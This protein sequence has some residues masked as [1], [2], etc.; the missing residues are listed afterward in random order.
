MMP[1]GNPNTRII[2]RIPEL[3]ASAITVMLSPG[4]NVGE[5][6]PPLTVEVPLWTAYPVIGTRSAFAGAAAVTI[7]KKATPLVIL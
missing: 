7:I 6:G 5:P 4:V 2:F 3:W 1:R